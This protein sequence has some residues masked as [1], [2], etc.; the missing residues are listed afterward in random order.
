MFRLK[1]KPDTKVPL[2]ADVAT[3]KLL[4]SASHVKVRGSSTLDLSQNGPPCKIA[5]VG[6]EVESEEVIEI[7]ATLYCA[8][9]LVKATLLPDAVPAV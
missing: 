1:D 2:V 5:N 3:V 7:F 6:S 9:V 8:V 4:V